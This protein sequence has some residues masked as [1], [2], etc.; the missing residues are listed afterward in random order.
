MHEPDSYYNNFI[1][2]IYMYIDKTVLHLGSIDIS[3]LYRK[4]CSFSILQFNNIEYSRSDQS[5]YFFK[6]LLKKLI[7]CIKVTLLRTFDPLISLITL[8]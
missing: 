3:I 8:I 1:F 2:S 7:R 6:T 4:K 5:L